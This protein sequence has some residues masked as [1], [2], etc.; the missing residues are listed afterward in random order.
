MQEKLREMEGRAQMNLRIKKVC[1][2]LVLASLQHQAL[3]MDTQHLL[4]DLAAKIKHVRSLPTVA[5][6]SCPLGLERLAGTPIATINA[7][8][9][10]PDLSLND[11]QWYF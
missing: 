3:A 10:K 7:V 1:F 9:P 4:T 11:S 5:K 2:A 8:L 6:P